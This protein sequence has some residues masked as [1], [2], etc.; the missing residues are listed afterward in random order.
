MKIRRKY[1]KDFEEL[2][3]DLIDKNI[4]T[5][6]LSIEVK[7]VSK[8]KDNMIYRC[9]FLDNGTIKDI[10][11]IAID[12]TQALAKLKPYVDIGIP[13]ET[14]KYMLGNERMNVNLNIEKDEE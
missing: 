8:V 3:N 12:V 13:E 14:L 5:S 2:V 11:I 4:K 10:P 7:N 9:I 1:K 6:I